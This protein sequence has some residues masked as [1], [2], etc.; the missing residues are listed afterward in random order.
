M[1]GEGEWQA[2]GGSLDQKSSHCVF[3][4]ALKQLQCTEQFDTKCGLISAPVVLYIP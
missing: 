1:G 2:K 4:E 3:I